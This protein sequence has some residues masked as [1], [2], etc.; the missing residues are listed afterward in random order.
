MDEIETY[1]A[2]RLNSKA[3]VSFTKAEDAVTAGNELHRIAC[4]AFG[5]AGSA[6]EIVEMIKGTV[7]KAKKLNKKW[8]VAPIKKVLIAS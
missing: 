8:L 7:A 2:N 5:G 6:V 3:A 4:S 1:E